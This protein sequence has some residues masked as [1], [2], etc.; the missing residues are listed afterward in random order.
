MIAAVLVFDVL[1]IILI[2]RL[3]RSARIR[4]RA[5]M[6]RSGSR[7]YA[8]GVYLIL[9][10]LVLSGLAFIR[11]IDTK[12]TIW[13]VTST[14]CRT[15]DREA[16]RLYV[17]PWGS[18]RK[19]I[20]VCLAETIPAFHRCVHLIKLG[21]RRVIA[22]HRAP[23]IGSRPRTLDRRDTPRKAGLGSHPRALTA[24][25]RPQGGEARGRCRAASDA[26]SP[27]APGPQGSGG[28]LVGAAKRSRE[29]I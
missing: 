25:S 26:R 14:A 15:A 18:E 17:R 13:E 19:P 4:S 16:H 21:P 6:T 7:Y 27:P 29:P 9:I 8:A 20:P 1:M 28:D 12:P 2:W 23:E 24:A 10:T 22:R 11:L 3:F 5:G